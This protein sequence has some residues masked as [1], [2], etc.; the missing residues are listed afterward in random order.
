MTRKILIAIACIAP[1]RAI[2]VP[3]SG[4][5]QQSAVRQEQ[6]RAEARQLVKRLD[7][8]IT[9][10]ARNG[11]TKGGD[12]DVLKNVRAM[13]GSL[14]DQEMEKIVELL[15]DAGTKP[16]NASDET[17]KAY[18]GQRGIS[19][20][21]KQIMAA[22][23]RQ[24][25]LDALG[26]AVSQLADR[27]SANLSTAIDVRQ[28]ATQDKSANGKTAV[29][30][31][32]EAQQGE[33]GAI[34]G[35]VKLIADKLAK[36][37]AAAGDPKYND[38]AAQLATV[39]PQATAATA[40]LGTGQ[41]DDAIAAETAAREK[42]KQLAIALAPASTQENLASKDAADLAS[43]A[44]DQKA[45]LDRTAQINSTLK[46]LASEATQPQAD[47]AMYQQVAKTTAKLAMQLAAEGI[48]PTS[49]VDQIRN[50]PE[51]QKFLAA[52]ADTLKKQAATISQKLSAQIGDQAAL[53]T[54]AQ[55]VR[56][57]LDKSVKEAAAPM[58]NALTQ[59]NTAQSALAQGDA[60]QAAQSQADAVKE[61]QQAAALAEKANPD[62][63]QTQPAQS[64]QQQLQQLQKDAADLAAKEAAS[65]NQ[66]DAQQTGPQA[67]AAAAV[68]QSM[69]AKA[70][71]MQ[72]TAAGQQS[73]AA[74]PL[75][76]AA[77]AM[78]NAAQ[79]MQHGGMPNIAQAAQQT[80]QQALAAAAQQLAQD[81]A[82]AAQE[83]QQL[84][85]LEKEMQALA[86]LIQDQQAV[87][88]GT[89]KA[90]DRR[91]FQPGRKAKALA[92]QQTG[93]QNETKAFRQQI[94]AEAP[95][96]VTQALDL[97]GTSMS[98]AAEKLSMEGAEPAVPPEKAALAALYQAQDALA[99]KIQ[100]MAQNL[101][102]PPAAPEAVANAEAQLANAQNQVAA[103]QQSMAPQN[104][105]PNMS[106]AGA[107]MNQAAQKTDQAAAQ[108]QAL[109]QDARDDIRQADQA[110]SAAAAAA[111]AGQ[112]QQAQAQAAQ[113]QKSLA[114]A[115]SA[116]GQMQAGVGSLSP[117]SGQDSQSEDQAQS[118]SQASQPG[119]QPS[120]N[121]KGMPAS[122]KAWNDQAGAVAR[123]LQGA[124]GAGQFLGLPE[125]DRAAL[126]QSQS[127][128]YPQ[129]YGA[130]IEEYMRSLASDSGGK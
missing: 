62:T 28:L 66:A 14:S 126:Q 129:E 56:E 103:A 105:Q 89:E 25:D 13:L 42:L 16:G 127:E 92:S 99:A 88:L 83:Q 109:P 50:A 47:K 39:A 31:S 46:L 100:Q 17:A 59:M 91:D 107:Q 77:A 108:A 49:P 125:R 52:R 54:K 32:E 110:A 61:L 33:Q 19:L 35:E 117:P 122:E 79:T 48:T 8:V 29:S 119:T 97:A 74:Q 51:M 115:Q 6:I 113:A 15:N 81:A 80:A 40:A 121:P 104:G 93:V 11:L 45:L 111:A 34:A 112:Q 3:D 60:Q 58:A 2:A 26:S 43:I 123:A 67:A 68:Q 64:K 24:Q 63:A 27:Q 37:A 76:Q 4:D 82:A 72:Q 120:K 101:G 36:I 106:L 96:P 118:D 78:N 1:L 85:A 30:A 18:A 23:E 87:N 102:Q 55:M 44:Q 75:Q 21:L 128:K 130:M 98:D 116:L 53:A 90:I 38:A 124:H 70:Q 114:A 57:D 95:P 22:H 5:I 12:L 10:Y 41:I 86:K 65:I 94:S 7:D 71:D 84:A 9:D 69:A 20:R 73:A